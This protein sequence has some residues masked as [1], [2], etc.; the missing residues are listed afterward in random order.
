MATTHMGYG[1]LMAYL[2]I[3]LVE[4]TLFSGEP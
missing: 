3:F 1:F 4:K 2:L